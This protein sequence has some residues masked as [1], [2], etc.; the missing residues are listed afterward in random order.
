MVFSGD[1]ARGDGGTV[2][3][4][5]SARDPAFQCLK[6]DSLVL[7][8]EGQKTIQSMVEGFENGE[9]FTVLTHTGSG[10]L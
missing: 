2:T 1:K 8:S 3:G 5:L 10:S 9:E 4:R 6:G 7:T